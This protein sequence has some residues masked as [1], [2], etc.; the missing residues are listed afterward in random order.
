MLK[1]NKIYVMLCYVMLC[2]VI[3][4]FSNIKEKVLSGIQ[5]DQAIIYISF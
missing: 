3:I 2:Y 1:S 4:F 5:L